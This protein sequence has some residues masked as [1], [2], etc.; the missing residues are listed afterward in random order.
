MQIAVTGGTGFIGRYMIRGLAA[1]GHAVRA[2]VRPGREGALERPPGARVE[3]H[4][5]DLTR[6]ETLQG[7]VSGADKVIHLASHN[8]V[9]LTEKEMRPLHIQG[10]EALLEVCRREKGERFEFIIM[11]SALLGL[12]VYSEWRDS[13]RVQEKIPRGSD[14]DTASFRPTTVYGV[15]DYRFTAKWLRQCAQRGGTIT[16]PHSGEALVNP[17]HVEDLVDAVLRYF[18]FERGVDCVY[19]IAGPKGITYNEFFDLTVAAAG[20]SVKRKNVPNEAIRR[21][22]F[23]KG[24]FRDVTPERRAFVNAIISHEHDITNARSELGWEPRPYAEGIKQV[25]AGDWWRNGPA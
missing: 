25:A 12:T 18:D 23:W 6:P 1:K 7:F 9:G 8:D 24:I 13:K 11:S 22:L 5:G 2:L 21:K 15:G 19:E 20:G 10:T 4:V 17:V 14:V 3:V 16:I